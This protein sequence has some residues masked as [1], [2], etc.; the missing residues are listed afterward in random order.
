MASIP[1]RIAIVGFGPRGLGALEALAR[2]SDAEGGALAVELFDPTDWP[3]AGPN[4]SPDETPVCLLNLPLRSIGLPPPPIGGG[5]E[6][7]F[8]AWLGDAGRDDEAFLPR[9]R[10]G[11]YLHARFNALLSRLPGHISV[12]LHPA[13]VM[14][15]ERDP[16]GWRL[17]TQGG[18][19]GPYDHVLLSLG[20]PETADDEQ[21]ARWR[22]HAGRHAL[23][24]ISA[25]PGSALVKAAEGWAGRT[26]GIRGM[27][28]S[29]LDVIRM[30]TLG[31]GGR[32]EDGRYVASGREPARIVPFSLDGQ[33]PAPKPASAA[34]DT[35]F[36]PLLA[37]DAAF[38]DA[39]RVA[40][41]GPADA[42]LAPLYDV[43]ETAALRILRATGGPSQRSAVN[44]WLKM[45]AE[46]PGSQELRTTRDALRANIAQAEG[47]EPPSIGYV[48][49]QLWR[50]WQ[51]P[52]RRIYDE[53]AVAAGTARAVVSFDDGLKRYSYGAPVDTARLLLA[54]IESG[55]VD[56]RAAE[57]PDIALALE[58]WKLQSGGRAVTVS[59]MIDS[60]L[61]QPALERV[62][63]PLIVE[64]QQQSKLE[65]LGDDL[66]AQCLPDALLLGADDAPVAGLALAGRLANGS[67][68]A[69][70][71]IH[72]CFGSICD[73]WAKTVFA[74][75]S[76]H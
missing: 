43:L 23:P 65:A 61:P 56:P 66:G 29:A 41:T 12:V 27:A 28:L 34:L 30:L 4:F 40:L 17:K 42:A 62:T 75:R 46:A 21:M 3:A 64:L 60:V 74:S 10:L 15:A 45:E 49:G 33:A 51:P 24:L 50:K 19:H 20:Q 67:T 55:L 71:S 44:E 16:Q 26:V 59:V 7:S 58:G 32:F 70:D 13:R 2:R 5:P 54:L 11:T 68:I 6:D 1:R 39:L 14:A 48:I 31:S 57:D 76:N 35:R 22:A 63:E 72:D 52:L 38:A 8:A 18:N 25:Y 37:E 69:S 36:D 53:T 47:A 9:A 73:R